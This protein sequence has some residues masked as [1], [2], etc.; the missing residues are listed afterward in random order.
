MNHAFSCLLGVNAAVSKQT[1]PSW[2]VF[3][4][5]VTVRVPASQSETAVGGGDAESHVSLREPLV[6]LHEYLI[7]AW[8]KIARRQKLPKPVTTDRGRAASVEVWAG[9]GREDWRK[10]KKRKKK[11]KNNGNHFRRLQRI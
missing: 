10:E 6:F 8:S 5:C 9:G 4:M 2:P 3:L 11:Q 1:F 7:D